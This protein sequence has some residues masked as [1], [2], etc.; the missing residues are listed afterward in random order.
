M[1]LND[2]FFIFPLWGE[3]IIVLNQIAIPLCIT[4]SKYELAENI[5]DSNKDMERLYNVN[6]VAYKIPYFF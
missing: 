5:N 6:T 3:E 4:I 2:T 1:S